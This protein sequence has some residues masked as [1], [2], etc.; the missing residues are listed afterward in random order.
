MAGSD[1][2]TGPSSGGA[3]GRLQLPQGAVELAGDFAQAGVVAAEQFGVQEGE[4]GKQGE[5][6]AKDQGDDRQSVVGHRLGTGAIWG[7]VAAGMEQAVRERP[8][9]REVVPALVLDFPAAVSPLPDEGSGEDLGV[10]RLH[11]NPLLIGGLGLQATAPVVLLGDALLQA[12]DLD[13]LGMIV[14]E[15]QTLGL[16]ES[17]FRRRSRPRF[18]QLRVGRAIPKQ[19]HGVLVE[20]A[21]LLLQGNDHVPADAPGQLQQRRRSVKRIPQQDVEEAAGNRRPIFGVSLTRKTD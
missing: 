4:G 11:P 9:L 2:P 6:E 5:A 20:V 13:R 1:G 10:Q 18:A 19:A 16:P 15:G 7:P 3:D 21:V 17:Y 8:V 14:G 12:Q